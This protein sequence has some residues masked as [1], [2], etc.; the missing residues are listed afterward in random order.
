[1]LATVSGHQLEEFL[2]HIEPA[3][4]RRSGGRSADPSSVDERPLERDAGMLDGAARA[5]NITTCPLGEHHGE[6]TPASPELIGKG[7]DRPAPAGGEDLE[8]AQVERHVP[9]PGRRR[10]FQERGEIGLPQGPAHHEPLHAFEG[11]CRTERLDG[12]HGSW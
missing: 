7:A 2:D 3:L 9:I 1:M 5:E 6:P 12:G 8:V 4:A 10:A 11:V